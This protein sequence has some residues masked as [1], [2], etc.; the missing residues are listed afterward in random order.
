VTA[1][2]ILRLAAGGDGVG[3]LADGRAVF[4]PRTAPGDLAELT[5]VRE[6]RRFARARLGRLIESSP[7]RTDPRCPHYDGDECGGCQLQHL[8]MAPQRDARRQFVGDALRRLAKRD[9]P[10]PPLVPS[11]R[12]FEY[13]TKVSLA[14]S[15]EGRRIG[16]HSFDRPERVF[17]LR[18]CHIAVPALMSLWESLRALR[19]LLPPRLERAVLRLDRANGRHLVLQVKKGAAWDGGARLGRELER[20]GSP[21]TVW[22]QP[23]G[24]APRAVAGSSEAFPATV[25]E[26]VHPAMGDAVRVYALEVLGEV[27]GR[28]VWDL[29]AGIGET[30]ALLA[31]AGARVESVESDARAVIEADSRGPDARRLAGRVEDVLGQLK[32]PELVVTNPP[33]AGMDQRVT[34]ALERLAPRRIVYISCDPAT[35]ARDLTRLPGYRIERLQ[36]FDLFPQT[37]HVETVTVLERAS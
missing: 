34:A 19:S 18:R 6:H 20:A 10:D 23:E 37:A 15:A 30:T 31:A 28:L 32:R 21:A 26:Q 5:E 33:R 17:D 12:D 14:V 22:W 25:F 1:V 16:L 35:L 27:T 24:G 29:Y 8:A 13:R 9:L 4:V 11:P 3:R 7:D 36:A 2:R